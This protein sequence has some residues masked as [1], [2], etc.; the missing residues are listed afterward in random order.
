MWVALVLACSTQM[1]TSCQVFANTEEFFYSEMKCQDN[2]SRMASYL[3]SKGA[4]A[5]PLCFEV[6]KAA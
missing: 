1:A 2:S 6:G 4:I 5:I 3:V